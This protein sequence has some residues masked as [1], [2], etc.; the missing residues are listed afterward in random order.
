MWCRLARAGRATGSLVVVPVAAGR[1]N[2]A[3]LTVL[4]VLTV[5]SH[6]RFR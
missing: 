2:V 6:T 1:M 4:T 3:V 5:R